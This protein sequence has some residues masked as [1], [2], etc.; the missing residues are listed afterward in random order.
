MGIEE[1]LNI[2]ET[3][4]RLVP[5]RITRRCRS[6]IYK[7]AKMAFRCAPLYAISASL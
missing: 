5:H 4:V 6:T 3:T 1:R 2:E 7:L